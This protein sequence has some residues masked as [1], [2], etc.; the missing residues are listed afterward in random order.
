MEKIKIKQIEFKDIDITTLK[1]GK[2]YYCDLVN[3]EIQDLYFSVINQIIYEINNKK[4]VFFLVEV[5]E[6]QE[7]NLDK[8]HKLRDNEIIS[9]LY[10]FAKYWD[11]NSNKIV[12]RITLIKE[13]LD[14]VEEVK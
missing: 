10:D 13:W 4:I 8:L 11:I 7:T 2:I 12:S 5:E 1:E 3:C 6:E 14:K 9:L